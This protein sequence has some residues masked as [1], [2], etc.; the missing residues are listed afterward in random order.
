MDRDKELNWFQ[1]NKREEKGDWMNRN[2]NTM[3]WGCL[4]NE[5]QH[6]ALN[7]EVAFSNYPTK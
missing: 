4:E 1:N 7:T 2:T 6:W 3:D 5:I